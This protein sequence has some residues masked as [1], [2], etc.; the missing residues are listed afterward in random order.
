MRAAS[1]AIEIAPVA[2]SR[3]MAVPGATA[4][5]AGAPEALTPETAATSARGSR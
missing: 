2:D 1:P 3:D 5:E 4:V